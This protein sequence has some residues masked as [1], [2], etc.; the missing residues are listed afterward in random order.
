M[1]C[2]DMDGEG[3]NNLNS[4]K[5]LRLLNFLCDVAFGTVYV[6]LCCCIIFL[7]SFFYFISN[8][9]YEEFCDF[10]FR[11]LRNWIDVQSSNFVEREKKGN[12][13][14]LVTTFRSICLYL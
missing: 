8:I 5:K 1:D 13:I 2:V 7:H 6:V 3:Y 11:E 14:D 12:V 4:S 9:I 10:A